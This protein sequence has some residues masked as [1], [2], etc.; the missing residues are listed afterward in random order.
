FLD[1]RARRPTITFHKDH[2]SS[3][4]PEIL[5]LYL[6]HDELGKPFLFLAG[7]EP[8]FRW[9]RFIRAVEMIIVEFD[10][11][12]TTW[13]HAIPMPVPHTRPIGVTVSGNQ[14]DLITQTSVWQPVTKL[15]ASVGHAIEYR[16]HQ[17]EIPVAGFVLLV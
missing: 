5:A 10:V 13:V 9:D 17:K 14:T 6:A 12:L 2:L 15:T 1:Y 7:Y 16:L 11:T 4:E 8:D 3:Y